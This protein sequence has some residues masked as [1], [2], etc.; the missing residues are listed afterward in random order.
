MTWVE[1]AVW[2]HVYPLG[3]TGAPIREPDVAPPPA[4][5]LDRLLGWL[6]HA[7]ALGANGLLLGPVFASASHGYDTLDH[8]AIDPRL[9]DD[10]AFDRLVA[11][12]RARGLR[13]V[14]DGVFN[15]LG[16][17]HPLVARALAEGPD[18]PFAGWFRI[19]WSA[20]GG[21]WPEVF[22]GHAGLVELNHGSPQVARFVGDVMTH[23][24]D[25][26]VDGWRLDAAY[27]VPPAFWAGVLA[28]VRA[29][30]PDAW[31]VGEV[32]HGDYAGYV[33]DS[34]LDSLTQYELWKAIWSSLA[35]RNF[36]EL[37]WSMR[38]H[39]EFLATFL[40][41][42]FVG[43]HDVTRIA[44]RVGTEAAVLGLVVLMTVGGVPSVYYGDEW[45]LTGVKEERVGGD[46]AIRP[47]FPAQPGAEGERV[48][49][50]HQDLVG[51]RRRHPWLVGARTRAVTT[52][53]TRY[54]Y[55]TS[56]GS[57]S[58]TV[59]LDV[60]TTPTARVLGPGGDVLFAWG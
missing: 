23:W 59:E 39:D 4:P 46:D 40:P 3:F 19:D 16:A 57:S 1:H 51:L 15:H 13:V 9:G 60:T 53:N 42:T 55:E 49:R 32:L 33:R 47:P 5:R 43:N 45:G 38:R 2:W 44:S 36:W 41:Q 31:F 11:A 8:L 27:R 25:R 6:D 18:G 12:C 20:P 37:D 14:L 30:H 28:G 58:L 35:D 7:V 10:E 56:D 24:L 17:G 26:G 50:A 29:A 52:T 34:T 54:V 48:F 22:E 21:P